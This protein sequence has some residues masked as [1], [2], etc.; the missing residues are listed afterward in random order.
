MELKRY[1]YES[2]LSDKYGDGTLEDGNVL[3]KGLKKLYTMK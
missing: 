1:I 3:A 2:I